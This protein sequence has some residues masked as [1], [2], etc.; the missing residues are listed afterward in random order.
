MTSGRSSRTAHP[1]A[2]KVGGSKKVEGLKS[3]TKINGAKDKRDERH[4]STEN[5]S[6]FARLDELEMLERKNDE[7][8]RL[9]GDA[10]DNETCNIKADI[11]KK[12][13]VEEE[14]LPINSGGNSYS[15]AEKKV[16][17]QD[18]NNKDANGCST[19]EE[20]EEEES[21]GNIICVEFTAS[22]ASAKQGKVS[23]SFC[24]LKLMIQRT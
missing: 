13:K 12:E 3:T 15:Q 8:N 20:D 11:V 10:F 4:F 9:E 22:T 16:T 14:L 23:H 7:F 17:W 18:V 19:S 2:Q 6:L 5:L 24:M 21:S 1:K